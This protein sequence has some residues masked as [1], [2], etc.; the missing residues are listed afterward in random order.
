[1]TDDMAQFES[2]EEIREYLRSELSRTDGSAIERMQNIHE[3]LH[4]L[5]TESIGIDFEEVVGPLVAEW[6]NDNPDVARGLAHVVTQLSGVMNEA[7]RPVGLILSQVTT[8]LEGWVRNNPEV[9]QNL[10]GTSELLA[11]DRQAAWWHDQY[12]KDGNAIPFERSV[13]LAFCL[14]ALRIPY[15]GDRDADES[16]LTQLYDVEM[17]AI[18]AL[19]EGRLKELIEGAQ[20]SPLDFRTLQEALFHLMQTDEP[21]PSELHEWALPVAA[22]I[23]KCPSV[24]PGRSRYTNLVRNELITK[25]VHILVDCGLSATRNEVSDPKSACDAVSKALNAHGVASGYA[26]VAKLWQFH[27]MAQKGK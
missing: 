13:R 25:T 11:A 16:Y 27:R 23:A 2:P 5:K 15:V 9:V 26:A 21:I 6:C 1:M 17:R 4:S 24:G 19:R 7:A 20:S 22:G 3:L 12:D 18:Y 14:M 8:A 10:V